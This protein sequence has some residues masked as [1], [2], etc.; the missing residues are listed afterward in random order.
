MNRIAQFTQAAP[1]LKGTALLFTSRRVP[2]RTRFQSFRDAARGLRDLWMTQPNLRIQVSIA[3]LV[4]A[5]GLWCRLV[6]V[7][8]LW[9]SFAIGLVIFAELMNTV[10]EQMV[11][12]VVGRSPDPL[13]R[14]VKDLAAGC[15]LVAAVLAIV[16]GTLTFLPHLL[17]G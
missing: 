7:E 2:R 1:P 17:R 3:G 11:D 16:I 13:A 6:S 14:Q 5:A 10:I 9:V 4:V 12:L 15:V 8:W